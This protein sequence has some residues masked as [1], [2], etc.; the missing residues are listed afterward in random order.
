MILGQISS[1]TWFV[2]DASFSFDSK[3]AAKNRKPL[4]QLTVSCKGREIYFI[5]WRLKFQ[6]FKS[7]LLGQNL[8][9]ATV[10]SKMTEK[11]VP[12]RDKAADAARLRVLRPA[13]AIPALHI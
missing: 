11:I 8:F 10:L 12:T 7:L 9:F 3:I 2:E 6:N 13:Y 5:I 1:A 4:Y